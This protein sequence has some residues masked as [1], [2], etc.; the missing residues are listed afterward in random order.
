[1]TE[2]LTGRAL[3][4]AVAEKVMGWEP[5]PWRMERGVLPGAFMWRSSDGSVLY[6]AELPAYS[7]TWEGLGLVVEEMERLGWAWQL[8]NRRAVFTKPHDI[9]PPSVVESERT[10]QISVVVD[11]AR[12]VARAALKALGEG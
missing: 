9:G 5:V 6:P 7:S 12:A 1:M 2:E 4:A 8:T 3:D 10:G 11:I